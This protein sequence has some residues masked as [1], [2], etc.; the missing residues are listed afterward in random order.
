MDERVTE[1]EERLAATPFYRWTGI[2]VVWASVG[3]VEP[4][5]E[6]EPHHLN[7]QGLAHGG[8]LATLADTAAG[9]AVR[10][11][12]E[13]GRRH[14]TVDLGVHFLAAAAPGC[15]TARGT[16]VRVGAQLAYAEVEVR[17]TRDRLLVKATA[18]LAVSAE[19]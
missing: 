15:V 13:P 18:T 5:M 17:D 11:K 12:L 9:L 4:A 14:G 3:E 6:I 7:I 19:S 8:M 16:A 10:T 1:L 2:S